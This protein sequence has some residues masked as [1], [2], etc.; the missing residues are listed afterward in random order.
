MDKIKKDIILT[1]DYELFFRNSGTAEL[2]IIEPTNHLM[3]L[4]K[5]Y[6]IRGTVYIDILYYKRLIEDPRTQSTALKIKKQLQELVNSGNRIELHLHPHWI[7]AL[8]NGS[9]WEFKSYRNYRFQSLSEQ[10]KYEIFQNGVELLEGIAKEVDPNYRILSYR[11]G[12]L[13]IQPFADF[14][15]FFI[16]HNIL[17]D[18]SVVPGFF[19]QGEAHKYDFRSAPNL[20]YYKFS[21][22]VLMIDTS[23][24]FVELPIHTYQY[25]LIDKLINYILLKM[26][27]NKIFGDGSY[28]GLYKSSLVKKTVNM[29]KTSTYFFSLENRHHRIISHK[30]AKSN[31]NIITFLSHPKALSNS[32]LELCVKLIKDGHN[33]LTTQDFQTKYLNNEQ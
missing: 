9:E 32:S 14:K 7:D 30:L 17:I 11:A 24:S 1:F 22:D 16:N 28:I 23:G 21:D 27:N 19:G 31:N 12:G 26:T 6:G 18:S 29:L 3:A 5:K 33:F 10:K 20:D 4:F 25:N 8:Y 15:P 13:C 2:S